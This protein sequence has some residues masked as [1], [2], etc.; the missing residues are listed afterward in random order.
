[1]TD[2][3]IS[4]ERKISRLTPHICL[5][6]SANYSVGRNQGECKY[7]NWILIYKI[8][9]QIQGQMR[10]LPT[11]P[12]I[13]S[14]FALF[15]IMFALSEFAVNLI[16]CAVMRYLETWPDFNIQRCISNLNLVPNLYA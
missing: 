2:V 11:L 16:L 15:S 4:T 9:L 6:Q 3:H 8:G 12:L 13:F 10:Y 5:G 1:M 14:L 7:R